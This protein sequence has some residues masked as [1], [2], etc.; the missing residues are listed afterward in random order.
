MN[1]PMAPTTAMLRSHPDWNPEVEPILRLEGIVKEFGRTRVLDNVDFEAGTGQVVA[2][3]G[4]NGAG[5]ST[6]MNIIAGVLPPTAGRI[7]IQGEEVTFESHHTAAAFGIRMVHQELSL[8]PQ[9]T[10]ME[11]L[12]L[13]A[14]PK[15][16]IGTLDWRAMQEKSQ[17]RMQK[18]GLNLN[19]RLR[20]HQLSIA[21]QQMIEICRE[22]DRN[23][24]IL[25]LDEPTS[26]IGKDEVRALFR[27]INNLKRER[28]LTVLYIS[29]RLDEVLEIADRI[30]ALRDGVV[31]S[32]VHTHHISHDTLIKTIIGENKPAPMLKRDFPSPRT[33]PV[34]PPMVLDVSGISS[35]AL[36][37]I[38]FALKK[39]EVL[40]LAGLTGSGRTEVLKT[41]YGALGYH[42]GS[43][44]IRGVRLKRN[45]NCQDALRQGV[46]LTPENRKEEGLHLGLSIKANISMPVVNNLTR[47]HLLDKAREKRLVLDQLKRFQVRA[48]SPEQIAGLLSGGNQQKVCLAKW[49]LKSPALLL[50]DEPTKGVD[51]GAK[52]EIFTCISALAASGVG[53]LFVSSEFQELLRVCHRILVL[54]D[55][56]IV[57]ELPV[58]E[59]LTEETIMSLVTGAGTS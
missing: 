30:V 38:T 15:R 19:P 54:R 18:I 8:F 31:V 25:I 46:C 51:I 28:Q 16:R 34:S 11:N 48:S 41:V 5:K 7:F 22:T 50:L 37:N 58:E 39:G 40:G 17:Q 9:L 3:V 44:S 47:W 13:T 29:H 27:L 43:I 56:R 49:T 14:L 53:M 12:L 24:K 42:T 4:Q 35:D 45:H 1:L 36:H 59:S 2:I 32:S 10:I 23:A 21:Q 26:A 55:G 20:I 33:A 6:L 52:E 57:R